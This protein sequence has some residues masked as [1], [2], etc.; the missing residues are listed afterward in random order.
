M[1]GVNYL[2][3]VS[4]VLIAGCVSTEGTMKIKGK[5]IDE[6]TRVE[7]PGREI[8]VE[9]LLE[10]NNKTVSVDAGNFSTD[11]SGCFTYKLSKVKDARNYNFFF[12]G[13]SEY[14]SVTKRISLFDLKTN[15]GYLNF[16]LNKLVDL[17]IDIRKTSKTTFRD[18]LYLTWKSDETD[19]RTLY[20]YNVQNFGSTGNT[21]GL[22]PGLGLRWIDGNVHSAV[23]TKVYSDKITRLHWELVRNKKRMEFTETIMC[24]RDVPNFVYFTY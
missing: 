22:V 18:T 14:A 21:F 7:I 10:G 13:D 3:L 19:F 2:K 4:A 5:V 12:V 17:T 16:S 15:A 1:R 23:K 6:I 11:S 20:P 24:K 8:I 9:A